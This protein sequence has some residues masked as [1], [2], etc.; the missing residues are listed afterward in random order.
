MRLT[1]TALASQYIHMP[2]APFCLK[3]AV[4]D[5]LPQ[6]TATICDLNINQPHEELLARVMATGPD[7]LGVCTYIWNRGHAAALIRRV[8]ALQPEI[9]VILGGPEASCDPGG[10]LAEAPADFVLRGA[11]EESLPALLRCLAEG[12]DPAEVPGCCFRTA[13]GLHAAAPAPTPPPRADLYDD[14]WHA[15]L[16][17][18]MAYVETSRGC[19]F[20]CAFCLSG[21][22]R[23][24]GSACDRTVQ[25][26]PQEEAL[27]LLIRIGQSGCDTVKLID[28][29][30]NCHR[31]RT[32][33]LLRGLID[34]KTRG[35]IGD[36]CYHF[37]VAA[38]LFD[39]EILDLLAT[40]PPGLFQ[41]EA[42]L[43]SFHAPTLDACDRHTDMNRLADRIRRILAPGNIHLHI[44]LIAGLP[45]EDFTTFGQSFDQAFA[46]QPHQLQLGFLKL[47]HGSR[48]RETDWGQRFSPDTPYEVLSTPW[49]AYGE[50]CRLHAA[51]EAVERIHNS[52]RFALAEELALRETGMRPFDLYLLLGERM[53]A[54]QGRWSLDALTGMVL[55]ALLSLGLD[56]AALRDAMIRD[57]LATD[58]T[59]YIP[60][61]L[62][63]GDPARVKAVLRQVREGRPGSRP[64]AALLHD[65]RIAL[66]LWERLHPVT[67]RGCVEILP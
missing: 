46:L 8:K 19:P 5:A 21:H 29:T 39:D 66:A 40:A 43:Q 28:R 22:H 4:D 18:R 48:L 61:V 30:F 51:A 37:E 60:P 57:R 50:L 53:A 27:A 52:G 23:P 33:Y 49:L 67:G 54:R 12:G 56:G 26:M 7:V 47:I 58:N 38:D 10:M 25:F 36:V 1:L 11:G 16:N 31:G 44:D 20:A 34:A 13:N 14:G 35:D 59:G 24:S 42:G 65:G 6:V 15:A 55:D 3:K 62:Q 64:R 32:E 17:G 41:M 45:L 2:L 9:V 63:P